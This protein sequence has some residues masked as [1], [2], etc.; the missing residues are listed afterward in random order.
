MLLQQIVDG[1]VAGTIYAALALAIVLIFRS[2]SLVNFAQGEMALLSTYV[3]WQLTQWG[4]PIVV[5]LL[6][7]VVFGFVL[8]AVLERTVIRPV[9]GSDHLTI[10]IVTLGLFMLINSLVGFTWGYVTKQFPSL[11]SR[12]IL[13]IGGVR[14]TQQ[15]IGTVLLVV[16]VMGALQ[17]F[18]KR[19]RLGLSIRAAS[20]NPDSAVL[21]GVNVSRTFMVSW[22]IASA[23]GAL[24]GVLVAPILFLQT[25]MMFTLLIYAFAAAVLGGLDS[26]LGALVGGLVLGVAENL[27]ATY[28]PFVPAEAKIAVAMAIIFVVLTIRPTGLFGTPAVARA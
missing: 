26:P 6:G 18:F 9:E 16:I 12:N 17:Q 1:A 10:V 14:I 3:A 11:F 20:S 28:V 19:T 13:D 2:M 23:L 8:G 21:V 7:A 27:S 25:N 5:A 24:A 4:A 15:A 22:G